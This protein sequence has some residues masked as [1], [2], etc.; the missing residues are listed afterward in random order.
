MTLADLGYCLAIVIA[1]G[2]FLSAL[3]GIALFDEIRDDEE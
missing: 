2:A 3:V 1:L